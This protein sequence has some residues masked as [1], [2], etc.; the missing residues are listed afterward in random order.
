[1]PEAN[2]FFWKGYDNI[3][4]ITGGIEEFLALYPDLIEGK[5]IPI[6]KP[7]PMS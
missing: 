7:K 2:K 5:D 1:M 4:L 6:V 3:C